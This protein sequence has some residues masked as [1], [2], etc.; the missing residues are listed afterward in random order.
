MAEL[1]VEE[2]GEH[3]LTCQ[4][5]VEFLVDMFGHESELRKFGPVD[6]R[7]VEMQDDFIAEDLFVLVP[8]D[9]MVVE[10]EERVLAD[11]CHRVAEAL[12]VN[13]VEA[14]VG[15]RHKI[16]DR[17]GGSGRFR[18]RSQGYRVDRRRRRSKDGIR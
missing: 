1:A 18:G 5:V 2:S 13:A 17:I 3:L 8:Y 11:E 14:D 16:V 10:M 15:G 7:V 12:E 9:R 4:L 6:C